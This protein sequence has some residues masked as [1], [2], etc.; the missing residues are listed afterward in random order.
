MSFI[1]GS[2]GGISNGGGGGGGATIDSANGSGISVSY[3]GDTPFVATA[4]TAGTNISLVPS[5]VDKTITVNATGTGGI[6]AVTTSNGSGI[7]SA[8]SG[9]STYNL[10]SNLVAGAGIQLSAS[11]STTALTIINTQNSVTTNG[12]GVTITQVGDDEQFSLNL[13]Q[14]A[15]IQITS[16]GTS[17]QKTIANTG[18]LSVTAGS[19][20]SLSGS[21]TNPTINSTAV[22]YPPFNFVTWSNAGTYITA[23]SLV[24]GGLVNMATLTGIV[25]N[26]WYQITMTFGLISTLNFGSS[27]A[28]T[29]VLL[30]SAAPLGAL[31]TITSQPQ[32]NNTLGQGQ[33]VSTVSFIIQAP[34]L[35]TGNFVISV[36]GNN[37]TAGEQITCTITDLVLQRLV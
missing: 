35:S 25:G 15:G 8:P 18:V 1:P 6:S 19:G 36:A 32:V 31:K 33:L 23:T 10:T 29:M 17:T 28:G 22:I 20:I 34:A 12:S 26:A 4:L 5:G 24:D 7:N 21:A 27:T 16:S 13:Q 37:C 2:Q 3:V 9:G 11:P 14:G 30:L